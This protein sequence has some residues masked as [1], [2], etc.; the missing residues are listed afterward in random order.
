VG[1]LKGAALAEEG[2]KTGVYEITSFWG[3][4]R[5]GIKMGGS[6]CWGDV[7]VRGRGRDDGGWVLSSSTKRKGE[8]L[9]VYNELGGEPG[10]Q[11]KSDGG[12]LYGGSCGNDSL[13]GNLRDK[14]ES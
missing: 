11:E 1:S 8:T 4:G 9:C 7:L 14:Q 12:G 13:K 3:G 2:E 6:G 10:F 5:I